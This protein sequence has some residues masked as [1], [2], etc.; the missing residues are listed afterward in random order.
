M[1]RITISN[2]AR[3]AGSASADL[4][5]R[6]LGELS[7]DATSAFLERF[8]TLDPVE[9]LAA[10]PEI[11]LET[12]LKKFVVRTIQ[13]R[14]YLYNLH[15]IDEPALK[16]SAEQIIVEVDGTAAAARTRGPFAA[17]PDSS[18]TGHFGDKTRPLPAPPR[19]M[20]C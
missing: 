19:L 7:N 18:P 15:Q 13:P 16:L 1:I 2:L 14:L 10:E 11:V 20:I 6:S 17:R 3:D 5:R 4:G 9:N 12:R 8:R